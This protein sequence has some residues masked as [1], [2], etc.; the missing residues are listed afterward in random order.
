MPGFLFIKNMTEENQTK[1]IEAQTVFL[2][3][4]SDFMQVVT[5]AS[6]S[7]DADLEKVKEIM[8]KLNY[9]EGRLDEL[10]SLYHL[11]VEEKVR[12]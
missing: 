8:A 1:L 2:E 5:R 11:L 4:L 12:T 3:R 10:Y 9:I 7:L 6:E